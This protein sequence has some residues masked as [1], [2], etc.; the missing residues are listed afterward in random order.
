M[1]EIIEE[2]YAF[3]VKGGDPKF[4]DDEGVMAFRNSENGEWMP[5]VGSD[6]KR[7]ESLKPIAQKMGTMLGL[8]VTI[9]KFTTRTT[10]EV[11][12]P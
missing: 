11:L 2:M 3:I 9:A 4:P 8:P 7:V 12:D 10:L 1:P 6:M 5:M